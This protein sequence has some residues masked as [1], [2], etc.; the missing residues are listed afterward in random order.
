[1]V[2]IGLDNGTSGTVGCVGSTTYF[3]KTPI[4]RHRKYTVKEQYI[5]RIDI[6]KLKELLVLLI[7]GQEYKILLENPKSSGGGKNKDTTSRAW[8]AT[9]IALEQLGLE[10]ET[11]PAVRWQKYLFPQAIGRA[12]QKAHSLALGKELYP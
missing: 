3:G 1:M 4:F 11:V 9:L 10:Y 2:F 12:S 6:S 7:N 5:S 8:E